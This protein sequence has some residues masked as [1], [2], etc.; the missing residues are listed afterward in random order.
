MQLNCPNCGSRDA[1]V[2]RRRGLKEVL[3]GVIGVYPLRCKRCKTRWLTS[4]WESAGWAYA[5]C[6]RCYRQELT[7]WDEKFY[8]PGRGTTLA[9]RLGAKPLRCAAC[10]CNFASFR[11]RK[12]KFEKHPDPPAAAP[13]VETH[14][15]VTDLFE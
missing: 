14:P 2:V 3:R 5:R 13:E 12:T 6:P 8:N 11:T 15:E 1:K 10:R 4:V 9:L 7:L